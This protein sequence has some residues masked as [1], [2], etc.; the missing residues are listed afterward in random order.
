[1]AAHELYTTCTACG[2]V[3]E[4]TLEQLGLANGAVRC[5]VCGETFNARES[6]REGIDDTDAP[7]APDQQHPDEPMPSDADHPSLAA[8]LPYDDDHAP[9]ISSESSALDED[10]PL[11]ARY[12]EPVTTEALDTGGK[13][14]ALDLLDESLSQGDEITIDI[15]APSAPAPRYDEETGEL[16]GLL[17]ESKGGPG[18]VSTVLWG[19]LGAMMLVVAVGQVALYWRDQW[20]QVAWLNGPLLALNER[21]GSPVDITYDVTRYRFVDRPRLLVDTLGDATTPQ[22]LEVKA[23]VTND[24]SVPQPLPHLRLILE[25]RWGRPVA[26]RTLAPSDYLA[27]GRAPERYLG[28]DERIDASARV[29]A[30]NAAP[31]AYTLDICLPAV[32]GQLDCGESP[33]KR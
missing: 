15:D 18:L 12:D 24:A 23:E 33:T 6:L 16:D 31:E 26:S 1:M 17:G 20:V 32:D 29:T 7:P 22:V 8:D 10:E 9:S 2:A 28:P 30:Q 14:V 4:I 25:D 3:F 19:M 13:L 27:P 11:V 21:L 5:G